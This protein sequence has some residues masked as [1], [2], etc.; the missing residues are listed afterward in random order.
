MCTVSCLLMIIVP[1]RPSRTK[2]T[3]SYFH[4]TI[5]GLCLA[6]STTEPIVFT[7]ETRIVSAKKFNI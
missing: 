3:V 5:E 4:S 7:R 1:L 2:V 6:Y